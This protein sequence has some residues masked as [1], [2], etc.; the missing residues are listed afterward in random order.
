MIVIKVFRTKSKK[1]E[2][3]ESSTRTRQR[4]PNQIS[5]VDVV[6]GTGS[7]G[8][9][10]RE[11]ED[12]GSSLFVNLGE[13]TKRYFLALVLTQV[14][15][16]VV[17]LIRL[18]ESRVQIVDSNSVRCPFGGEATRQVRDG[19]FRR[20]V[21]DLSDGRVDDGVG[22]GRDY[23]DRTLLLAFD[24]EVGSGLSSVEH[25]EN[26]DVEH[27]LEVVGGEFESGF[28]DRDTRVGSNGVNRSEVLF[29]LSESRLDLVR[30]SD[31][32]LVSLDSLVV[33][34]GEVGSDFLGVLGRVVDHG[35]G[36]VGIEESFRDTETET[37]VTT[38]NDYDL[39]F[40]VDG[41]TLSVRRE[42]VGRRGS[43][44]DDLGSRHD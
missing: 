7:V 27:L 18:D 40:K 32:A 29:D 1:S 13:T 30:V 44:R 36:S 12:S 35:D 3:D 24:P 2:H 33:L 14:G 43:L 31:V 4:S 15:V 37:T 16:H 28:D 26:V 11:E 21:E 22:H 5:S 10:L 42:G 6:R 20:V 9:I 39:S 38:S 34:L 25:T 19:T 41:E 8:R 17:R 23:Y